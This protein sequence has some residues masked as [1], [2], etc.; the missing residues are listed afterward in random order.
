MAFNTIHLSKLQNLVIFISPL[1]FFFEF[2]LFFCLETG[3]S[4]HKI[5]PF[6]TS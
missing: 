4:L 3:N 5:S 6:R 2:V 1:C